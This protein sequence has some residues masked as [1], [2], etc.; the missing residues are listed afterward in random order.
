MRGDQRP[1]AVIPQNPDPPTGGAG[2]TGPTGPT[3][4]QG[5]AGLT[6]RGT[7]D[8]DETYSAGDAVY[9]ADADPSA[10]PGGSYIA[11]SSHSDADDP[12][13]VDIG[14]GD[15]HA[16][17]P[18]MGWDVL[19][20]AGATGATG[21]AGA[22]GATGPTGPTGPAGATGPT[23]P[24]GS[25][26]ARPYPAD[27]DDLHVWALT[28]TSGS[29]FANS[30]S[31]SLALTASG[32]V[33]VGVPGMWDAA[34]SLWPSTAASAAS[35]NTTDDPTSGNVTASIWVY[36]ISSG[37]SCMF[38]RF[39]RPAS[40]TPWSMPYI[41]WMLSRDGGVTKFALANG[42]SGYNQISTSTAPEMVVGQWN[43]VGLTFDGSTLRGY[44]N[45]QLAASGA[46]SGSVYYTSAAPYSV[47]S[48]RTSTFDS[49]RA[50]YVDARVA[51]VARPASWFREV[52]LRG[53]FGT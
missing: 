3:G 30:G 25:A 48:D 43:H 38:A 12:P 20:Q 19:A 39:A 36:L 37:N 50:H 5:P 23:G 13:I 7:W 40:P 42:A 52:Y 46:V 49:V 18:A 17:V 8:T 26:L 22:D 29:T 28:E 16:W 31:S 9:Y 6:W 10:P 4:P 53:L 41:A 11:T 2:A 35:A 24:A 1:G 15:S 32:S 47:G 21:A 45:G 34:L 27:A 14:I 44:V 51:S 33:S